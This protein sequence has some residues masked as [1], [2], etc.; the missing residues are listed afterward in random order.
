VTSIWS[1]YFLV[2]MLPSVLLI[3][4]S[5]QEPVQLRPA[6]FQAVRWGAMRSRNSLELMIFVRF[7]NFG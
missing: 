4:T 3:T 7:Q 1:R 5:T 2:S 6:W